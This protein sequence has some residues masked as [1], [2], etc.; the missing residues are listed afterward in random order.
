MLSQEDA[1]L[2]Q[3]GQGCVSYLDL[4]SV[5]LHGSAGFLESKTYSDKVNVSR[6]YLLSIRTTTP[7]ALT[8]SPSQ[9]TMPKIYIFIS[10]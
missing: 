4:V 9:R 3:F 7:S 2:N 10:G 8:K 6:G 5:P 1:H